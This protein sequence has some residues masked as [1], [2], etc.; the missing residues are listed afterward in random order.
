M[1]ARLARGWPLLLIRAVFGFAMGIAALVSPPWS[2]FGLAF[3]IA[4]YAL[5][6][7]ALSLM[8][9]VTAYDQRGSGALVFEAVV[10]IGVGVF[11]LALP[12]VTALWLMDVFAVWAFLSGAAAIAVAIALRRELSGEWPL[13][14]AGVVSIVCSLWPLVARDDAVDPRWVIGPYAMLFGFTLLALALRLR[15]LALEIAEGA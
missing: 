13:P 7:G 10:R 2:T 11:V 12:G 3:L 1:L 9:A 4:A 8:L 15:R 6:D 14:L 5:G